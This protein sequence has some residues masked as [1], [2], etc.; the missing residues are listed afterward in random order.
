M[1]KIDRMA[2]DEV[3]SLP[4]FEARMHDLGGYTVSFET[5]TEDDD[6]A[7]LFVGLP[8]DHCQCP[9]WGYVLEGKVTYRYLDGSSEVIGAGEAYY[10]P[11]GHLPVFHAGSSIVEFSPTEE[12]GKT[13]Q[14][15]LANLEATTT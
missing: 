10:A 4:G 5:Y 6:P 9:H 12:F 14:V 3:E 2:V 1:A 15:V 13:V 11:P 7:P 8:D